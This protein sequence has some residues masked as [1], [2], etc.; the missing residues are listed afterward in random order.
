MQCN[1]RNI[2]SLKIKKIFFHISEAV[3]NK[4]KSEHIFKN[5]RFHSE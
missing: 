4:N 2:D 1:T 3:S 5:F